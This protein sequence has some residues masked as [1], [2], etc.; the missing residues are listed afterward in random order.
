LALD[1]ASRANVLDL[2]KGFL[3]VGITPT[4]SFGIWG[5]F[6]RGDLGDASRLRQAQ[7]FLR[8]FEIARVLVRFDHAARFIGNAKL[9]SA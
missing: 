9:H 7:A 4:K 2:L 5:N 6:V 1:V 3:P 8:L